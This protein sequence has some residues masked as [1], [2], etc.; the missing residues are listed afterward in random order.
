MRWRERAGKLE[1]SGSGDEETVHLFVLS[2]SLLLMPL[3]R[4][5]ARFAALLPPTDSD[6]LVCVCECDPLSVPIWVWAG[7]REQA[8]RWFFGKEASGMG[9]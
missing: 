5:C 9:I 6:I 8:N 2:A 3:Y 1:T 4:F 7:G